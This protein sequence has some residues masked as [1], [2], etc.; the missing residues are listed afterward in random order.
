VT[1]AAKPNYYWSNTIKSDTRGEAEGRWHQVK[2]RIKDITGKVSLNL[3]EQ[4]KTRKDFDHHLRSEIFGVLLGTKSLLNKPHG[5]R[6]YTVH[7]SEGMEAV[8]TAREKEYNRA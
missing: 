2:G 5:I 6:I 7:K 3:L 4:W 8:H 1:T